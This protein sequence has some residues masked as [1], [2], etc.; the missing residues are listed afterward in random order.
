[1]Q[2]QTRYPAWRRVQRYKCHYIFHHRQI[3]YMSIQRDINFPNWGNLL[4]N[5]HKFQVM[6]RSLK[7]GNCTRRPCRHHASPS[8]TSFGGVCVGRGRVP[9]HGPT[10]RQRVGP[11]YRQNWVIRRITWTKLQGKTE[12]SNT[13][14]GL[15]GYGILSHV[16]RHYEGLLWFWI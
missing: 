12:Y 11:Q 2:D 16:T 1:M 9:L 15:P 7:H 8:M 13:Q 6:Q 4:Q 5:N 14:Q 10:I 3:H